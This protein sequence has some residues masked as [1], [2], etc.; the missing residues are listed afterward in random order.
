MTE[1][2]PGGELRAD[3]RRNREGLLAVARE[4]FSEQGTDASLRDVARRAG[5]GIGTLYRHFPTREALLEAILH[6][7]F[8][9][10]RTSADELV[11]AE[12]PGVALTRWLE[13]FALRS[14][15]YRGLPASVMSALHDEGSELHASC[16]A[17]Y[18]AAA[19]LLAGAQAAGA[20][21]T[22]VEPEDLFAAAAA[23]GWAAEHTDPKRASRILALLNAG[24]LS[25]GRPTL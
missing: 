6:S 7:G 11:E 9:G 4:V 14:G 19:R 3:A 12:P 5:V 2:T 10:L 25:D 8:E 21:R 15:A 18:Q 16:S 17:M 13:E 22:D 23:V 20:V 1:K 24:L